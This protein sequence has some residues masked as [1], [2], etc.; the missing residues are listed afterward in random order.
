M[1]IL[2]GGAAAL[3]VGVGLGLQQ[4]FNDFTSGIVLLFERSVAVG[5]ILEFGD[6][7]GI[8]QQIGMRSSILETRG[9]VS[10]VVPNSKL[11]N[12]SIINWTHFSSKV[13]FSVDVGVSYGCDTKLVKKLLLEI[14]NDSPYV[15]QYP[16]PFVRFQDFG[17]SSLN[18]SL[19]FFSRNCIII[20]DIKSDI[21]FNIDAAFRENKIIIPFP[22]RDLWIKSN[23]GNNDLSGGTF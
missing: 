19:Y 20:E 8:V 2:L 9:N 14:A 11:V 16:A 23:L 3:L 13:R 17:D 18:M 22:Q 4:T 10:L 5:D 6:K 12:D 1:T 21:R 7:I 15:L